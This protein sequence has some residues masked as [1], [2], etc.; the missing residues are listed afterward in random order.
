MEMR[1]GL[2]R[3]LDRNTHGTLIY[4]N[5]PHVYYDV[6]PVKRIEI[7]QYTHREL[8]VLLYSGTFTITFRCY[9]PFG[10]LFAPFYDGECTP[11]LLATT[12]ILPASMM[13]ALPAP[14]DT[15]F[16]AYNCGTEKAPLMIRLAGDVGDGLTIVNETTGQTCKVVGLT[17]D[18]TPPGAYIEINSE[19][20][21]VWFIKGPE[22][23]LAFHY[24]DLGY[25]HLA[26]CTPFVRSMRVTY[27]ASSRTITTDGGFLPVMEG[28]Y[29]FLA[30]HWMEIRQVK[31]AC[32]A[33]LRSMMTSTGMADT[34]V[35]TMNKIS[36]RGDSVALSRLEIEYMPRV[37]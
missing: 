6:R 7:K 2:M 18:G 24:H 23:E 29:L 26:P 22:Q 32:T 37:R 12:G 21:Q 4:D 9:D 27:T 33:Q 35:V 14:G 36:L 8:G 15:A 1:E 34:P 3:W 13:P 30:G 5:K 19:T 16:L 11:E 20:G 10:K 17:A 28:Q 25:L 31:D